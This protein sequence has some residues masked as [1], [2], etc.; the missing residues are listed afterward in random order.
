[1]KLI[2]FLA[3]AF[4]ALAGCD[5]Q[6]QQAEQKAAELQNQAQK[7]VDAKL[8]EAKDAAARKASEAAADAQKQIMAKVDP[9][10]TMQASAAKLAESQRMMDKIKE[11]K[12]LDPEVQKWIQ[13]QLAD[14]N[15]AVRAAAIPVI[16]QAYAKVPEKR[17][18]LET[19]TKK[20]MKDTNGAVREAWQTLVDS[21]AR[22]Q[23]VAEAQR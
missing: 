18:W 4:L 5:A 17:A 19:E 23:S 21:W 10:G 22:M 11:G 6:R 7:S 20:A 3:I 13:Q 14:S 12:A 16:N 1:M 15:Q 8:Q 2:P 9:D